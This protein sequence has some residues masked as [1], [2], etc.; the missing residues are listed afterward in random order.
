MPV[1]TADKPCKHREEEAG[2]ELTKLR[3]NRILRDYVSLPN[4]GKCSFLLRSTS[5]EHA[6]NWQTS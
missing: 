2:F 4:R 5:H 1:V 6:G 3:H